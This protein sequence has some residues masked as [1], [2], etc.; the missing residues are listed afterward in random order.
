[1][2]ADDFD[3]SGS[4]DDFEDLQRMLRDM[5][6]GQGMP[7][8][9]FD[10]EKFA[11]A[12][13]LPGDPA[14]LKK[15]FETLRGAMNNTTDGVDWSLARKSAI[16]AAGGTQPADPAPAERA[17]PVAS[18][19]LDEVTT[20]GT[21]QDAPR[22]VS[23]IEW[24]QQTIDTW[25]SLAEPVAESISNALLGALESQV[26]EEMRAGILS[27]AG[28][29]LRNVGG[30]LFAMQLGSIVGRISGEV[31][32]AGD[33]GIPL[34]SGAGKEGG[35]LL[36]SGVAAFASGLEQDLEAV[37]LY[38]AVRELAHARLFRHTKWLRLSLLTAITDYAREIRIDTARMEEL[39][40]DFD[41]SQTEE[42]QA[43]LTSGALIPPKTPEQEAAHARL[44][45]MLALIDGWV[46]VVTEQATKRLPGANAIA[47]MVRRRRAAGGP[48]ERAFSALAGLE[49]RPR[50]MREAAAMWRLV[51]ERSDAATRDGLWSHPDL[52]PTGD[53]VDDPQSLLVRLGLTDAEPEIDSFDADLARLLSGDLP[54]LKRDSDD[55]DGVTGEKDQPEA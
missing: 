13:G 39:A 2:G 36:P 25:I 37:T 54:P 31:V 28:P 12:A 18:L 34:F 26:P 19:W 29:M 10:P 21:T 11:G 20:L 5:L 55:S 33:V 52:L 8:G 45:T 3:R 53:E 27:Q 22:T 51:E 44:E 7:E 46:D 1:M 14:A 42:F 43:L 41:P 49:L 35:A 50:R 32:S 48:A 9:G 47:E 16:E 30:A 15:L 24:V 6:S 17:F 40:R 23:R 4:N 38:L